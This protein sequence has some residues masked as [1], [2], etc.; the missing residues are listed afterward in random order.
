[1]R[2]LLAVL[3]WLI[4]QCGAVQAAGLVELAPREAP[5]IELMALNGGRHGLSDLRGKVVLVNFWATWCPPCRAEMPSLARLAQRMEGK[6]FAILGV[7]MGETAEEVKAF[8]K[9]MPVP[10]PILMDE[11]G[12]ALKRWNVIGFPSTFLVDAKGIL[13]YGIT[14]AI[15]W[16][17]PEA[18]EAI[19]KLLKEVGPAK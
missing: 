8:L 9:E 15:E 19:E 17:A 14:G 10:F 12:A 16:D 3:F 18:V 1:M 4:P 11:D 5:A 7:D 2:Y 6:S 13:R